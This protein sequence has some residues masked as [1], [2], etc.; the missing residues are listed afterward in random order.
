MRNS[1]LSAVYAKSLID[2]AIEKNQLE[3]VFADMQYLQT[4]CEVS[5]E[6]AR[7]L[8]SPIINADKK[9]A[10]VTAVTAKNI[11]E[12]T[13]AF[14]TL[15]IKKGR[16]GYLPQVASA[17]L[18]QYN[19]SKGIHEVQLTTAVDA[20]EDLKKSIITKLKSEAGFESV[21]LETVTNPDIIGGF[22]LEYDNNLIDA[23]IARDLKDIKKQFSQNTY[24]SN[25]R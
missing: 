25:L 9:Q 7:V 3:P 4:V 14:V 8:Q 20:S 13:T 19:E 17:F 11:G 23:S 15:L 10:I 22:I 12:I 5:P 1:R 6:F 16:E 2:L 24:V 21:K 18:S